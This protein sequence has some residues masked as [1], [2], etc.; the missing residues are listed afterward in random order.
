MLSLFKDIAYLLLVDNSTWK[1][2]NGYVSVNIVVKTDAKGGI[3]E[4]TFSPLQ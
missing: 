4:L 1:N 2:K 3:V